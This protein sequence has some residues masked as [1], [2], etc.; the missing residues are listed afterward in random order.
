M[1]GNYNHTPLELQPRAAPG[2]ATPQRWL[3]PKK[4]TAPAS[5]GVGMP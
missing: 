1:V 3:Q 4:S 2:Q 5:C